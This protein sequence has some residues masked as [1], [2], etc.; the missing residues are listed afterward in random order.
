MHFVIIHLGTTKARHLRPNLQRLS[1]LFPEI[2]ITK[3]HNQLG[4]KKRKP[5]QIDDN[6]LARTLKQFNK[7][8]AQFLL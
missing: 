6:N 1:Y 5:I 8:Y 2:P 7:K 4:G 3:L